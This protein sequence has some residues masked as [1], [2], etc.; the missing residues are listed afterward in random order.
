[1]KW[2]TKNVEC[3]WIPR[4]P[5]KGLAANLQNGSWLANAIQPILMLNAPLTC[6][7]WNCDHVTERGFLSYRV[8]GGKPMGKMRDW[9]KEGENWP[10]ENCYAW[11]H[12]VLLSWATLI[13]LHDSL[14]DILSLQKRVVLMKFQR[15]GTQF[16][17]PTQHT[18]KHLLCSSNAF[19][20]KCLDTNVIRTLGISKQIWNPDLKVIWM[21]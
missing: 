18:W 16:S 12:I 14:L 8:I 17:L 15:K 5:V 10:S 9:Q 2:G 6:C 20:G 21:D 7:R 11:G 19:I 1:M 13:M 4:S 3:S